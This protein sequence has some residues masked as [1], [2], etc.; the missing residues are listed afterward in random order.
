MAG[1]RYRQPHTFALLLSTSLLASEMH[2]HH[3]QPQKHHTTSTC[4]QQYR[5]QIHSAGVAAHCA[6][7][8][9]DKRK[10]SCCW[11]TQSND[12]A[13]TVKGTTP[14]CCSTQAQ[15]QPQLQ[16]GHHG[17]CCWE[18]LP[19]AV[20]RMR[21]SCSCLASCCH[22]LWEHMPYTHPACWTAVTPAAQH[23]A[24]HKNYVP[25]PNPD[26]GALMRG[27]TDGLR[28]EGWRCRLPTTDCNPEASF[29][30]AGQQLTP[31]PA[32]PRQQHQGIAT[33]DQR[34]LCQNHTARPPRHSSLHLL[35]RTDP[36][37]GVAR[38][39]F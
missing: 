37:A 39:L 17:C 4:P 5:A 24:S 12:C 2:Q 10:Q 7:Q 35:Q 25:V 13:T 11:S 15:L 34:L 32:S 19:T 28:H 8:T 3:M 16:L 18:T 29:H 30:R 36:W 22:T 6:A 21:H 20:P 9:Q 38:F 1:G 31:A 23:Q 27:K 26:K 33:W 14:C